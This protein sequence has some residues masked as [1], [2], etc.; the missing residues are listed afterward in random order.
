MLDRGPELADASRCVSS[1]SRRPDAL[2]L[3]YVAK[4]AEETGLR[5]NHLFVDGPAA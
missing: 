2:P 1:A 4:M 3:P 5:I